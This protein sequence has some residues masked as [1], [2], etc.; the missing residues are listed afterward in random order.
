[1]SGERSPDGILLHSTDVAKF[2]GMDRLIKTLFQSGCQYEEIIHFVVLEEHSGG[3]GSTPWTF[4]QRSLKSFL[5]SFQ[6]GSTYPTTVR[7]EK[8]NDIPKLRLQMAGIEF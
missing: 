1:M 6:S 4:L 2:F 8:D 5:Q 3:G 7:A